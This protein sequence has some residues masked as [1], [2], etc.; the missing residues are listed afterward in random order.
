MYTF[1]QALKSQVASN[2]HEFDDRRHQD[3]NSRKAAVALTIVEHLDEAAP[4]LT[5]RSPKLKAHTGGV[6]RVM[7][8]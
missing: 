4:I 8:W 3:E 2:L 6:R 7:D 5:R 1:D